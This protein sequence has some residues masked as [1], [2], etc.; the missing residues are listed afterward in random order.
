MKKVL[1]LLSVILFVSCQSVPKNHYDF[2]FE[3]TG[4]ADIQV[5]TK[6]EY[7]KSKTVKL[8]YTVKADCDNW[9]SGSILSETDDTISVTVYKNG[10]M[11]KKQACYPGFF[12]ASISVPGFD[13]E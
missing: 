6:R 13:Y 4:K 2:V 12:Y 11:L 3:G 1:L 10:V 9:I 5:N 8:P 7:L